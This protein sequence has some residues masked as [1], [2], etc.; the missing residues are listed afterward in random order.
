MEG[1]FCKNEPKLR[2]RC[3]TIGGGG[4]LIILK[5]NIKKLCHIKLEETKN[6]GKCTS[7]IIT[8][9]KN[10]YN[11]GPTPLGSVHFNYIESHDSRCS[12]ST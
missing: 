7:E 4:I 10:A 5:N 3:I 12:V 11:S 1:T 9:H 2:C 8:P 6:I